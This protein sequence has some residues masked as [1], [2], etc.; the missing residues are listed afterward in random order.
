MTMFVLQEQREHIRVW[1]IMDKYHQL[2][3]EPGI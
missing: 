1:N 2:L 3:I